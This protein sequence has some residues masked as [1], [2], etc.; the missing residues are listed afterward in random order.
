MIPSAAQLSMGVARRCTKHTCPGVGRRAQ[1]AVAAM[2]GVQRA[3]SRRLS[4]TFTNA[5]GR[6]VLLLARALRWRASGQ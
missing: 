5:F 2:P 3:A 6:A 1:L 4:N